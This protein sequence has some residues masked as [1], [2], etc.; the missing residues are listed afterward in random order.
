LTAINT[1]DGWPEK[2]RTMQRNWIGKS[3]GMLVRWEIDRDTAVGGIDELEVYTT[4][5]ELAIW[6]TKD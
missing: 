6:L 2:V 4:R 1:L 3:E 5:P